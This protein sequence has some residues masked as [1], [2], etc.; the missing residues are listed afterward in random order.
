M[1]KT[2]DYA[3]VNFC[4]QF[5]FAGTL[6]VVI[7]SV[8]KKRNYKPPAKQG[9]TTVRNKALRRCLLLA[10]RCVALG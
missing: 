7:R 3:E 6:R 8:T 10:S 5:F 1:R 4:F 9:V 2:K